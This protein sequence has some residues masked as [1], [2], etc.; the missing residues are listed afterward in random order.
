MSDA[1][2]SAI[3]AGNYMLLLASLGCAGVNLHG[4][5]SRFLSASLG[6]HNPGLK[7]AT[8][9]APAPNGFYTPIASEK[10]Q[11]PSPRPIFYGMLLAQQFA[12]AHLLDC[13]LEADSSLS[14]YAAQHERA[15]MLALFNKGLSQS[16]SVAVGK[17]GGCTE[18]HIWKLLAP[19]ADATS[20]VTLGGTVVADDG[21]WQ[22]RAQSL[23]VT[24]GQVRIELPPVSAALLFL[25]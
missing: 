9:G 15:A 3:W 4:G 5:D 6:D 25:V 20:G 1:F 10:G 2:A 21:G 13:E 11:S 18:A 19:A 22:P 7:T 16:V 17:D 14:A 8:K 12:G 23:E 24:N